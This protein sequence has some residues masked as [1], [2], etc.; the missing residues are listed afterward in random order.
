MF[1][2]QVGL[3]HLDYFCAELKKAYITGLALGHV[4]QFTYCTSGSVSGLTLVI[5]YHDTVPISGRDVDAPNTV[6]ILNQFLDKLAGWNINTINCV[7]VAGIG[8]L[9]HH[10]VPG[11]L[12]PLFLN[13]HLTTHLAIQITVTHSQS[14]RGVPQS[15][16]GTRTLLK[17][18]IIN[19]TIS[20]NPYVWF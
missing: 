10:P 15:C 7:C 17:S 18:K 8:Y 1:Y 6:T 5:T 13:I 12:H 2:L 3:V 20:K 9:S 4:E 19:S 16:T 14:L 11:V